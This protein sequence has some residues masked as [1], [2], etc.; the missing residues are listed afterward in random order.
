[1]F[2]TP[3]AHKVVNLE[4]FI[5]SRS[6]KQAAKWCFDV[7]TG[8][9]K[10]ESVIFVYGLSSCG[11]TKLMH[12]TAK[13]YRKKC[14]LEPIK[15]S[16]RQMMEDYITSINE[17]TKNEFYNK[18]SSSKLLLI[19]DVHSVI[20]FSSTQIAFADIFTK[21]FEQGVNII[22]FSS[23]KL[24]RFDELNYKLKKANVNLIKVKIHK[25]DFAL[26][27]EELRR[28]LNIENTSVLK[29]VFYYIVINKKI[30]LASFRGCIKKI[31]LTK[32]LKND[33]LVNKEIIKI[34]KE[35]ER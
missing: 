26:R 30:E 34:L 21:L 19:D 22:L 33:K 31:S 6:N 28:T 29:K 5:L 7:A 27:K 16:F 13:I 32:I 9:T 14:E 1:M 15:I 3:K 12:T 4:G 25:A 17:N 2:N 18:Y 20:G 35:Y 23:Y 8:H 11:K 24:N 10:Q